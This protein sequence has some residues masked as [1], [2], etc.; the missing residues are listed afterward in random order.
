MVPREKKSESVKQKPCFIS[1]QMRGCDQWFCSPLTTE[2]SLPTNVFVVVEQTVVEYRLK[3][4]TLT[5]INK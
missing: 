1:Q 3:Q 4:I 5:V 2:R